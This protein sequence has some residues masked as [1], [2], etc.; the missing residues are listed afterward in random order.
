MTTALIHPRKIHLENVSMFN[1]FPDNDVIINKLN[2]LFHSYQFTL[3][4]NTSSFVWTN[5]VL[6]FETQCNPLTGDIF[7]RDKSTNTVY[8]TTS[9]I[10]NFG[11]MFI[12]SK[13]LEYLRNFI[14]K[15]E[16]NFSDDVLDYDPEL[17][18]D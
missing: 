12:S 5:G 7:K 10:G 8:K 9:Q 6:T 11:N 1:R 17:L 3:I 18:D 16:M 13:N 4:N 2:E 15:F 14:N